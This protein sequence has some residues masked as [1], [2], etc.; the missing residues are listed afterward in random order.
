MSSSDKNRIIQLFLFSR[1]AMKGRS[2]SLL[3]YSS[4]LKKLTVLSYFY[5]RA[6]PISDCFH[7]DGDSGWDAK[8]IGPRVIRKVP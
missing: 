2:L 8:H 5:S 3:M 4:V 7:A 1:F 6:M